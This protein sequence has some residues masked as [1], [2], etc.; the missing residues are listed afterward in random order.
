MKI[1]SLLD[2]YYKLCTCITI[3]FCKKI[4][5]VTV[6]FNIIQ[7]NEKISK[8]WINLSLNLQ[9]GDKDVYTMITLT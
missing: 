5:K 1:E 8:S 4:I 7:V 9:K 6:L 2:I 3:S